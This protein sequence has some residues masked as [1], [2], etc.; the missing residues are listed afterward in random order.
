MTLP[1]F[2]LA[3]PCFWRS[4]ARWSL[5]HLLVFGSFQVLPIPLVLVLVTEP[6]NSQAIH[7][8]P[9]AFAVASST[10]QILDVR[11]NALSGSLR[12]QLGLVG[13]CGP[14]L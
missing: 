3:A 14:S 7:I 12:G 4:F 13:I 1:S 9:E 11:Q 6:D 8:A 2:D 10:D 5:A